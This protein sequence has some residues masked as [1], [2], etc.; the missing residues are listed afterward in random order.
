MIGAGQVPATTEYFA[1]G[2]SLD[3]VVQVLASLDTGITGLEKQRL[4]MDEP[5]NYMPPEALLTLRQFLKASASQTP[6]GKLS[7]TFRSDNAFL[8]IDLKGS[9]EPRATVLKIRHEDSLYDFGFQDESDGTKRLFDL[10]DILF[11]HSHEKA[12]V[13]DELSRSFH[14]MLTQQLVKLFNEVHAEDGCQLIFTTHEDAIMSYEY[15]RRDEIWFVER[16]PDGCTRRYPLDRFAQDGAR[17]DARIG[18]K[19]M[20]GRYGGVPRISGSGALEALSAGEG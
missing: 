5:E 3:K 10:M 4:S 11:T 14:P 15:F 16:G 19:H 8:G 20:E 12:F 6:D 17:S 7:A 9:E 2:S 18:K 1:D 13:I